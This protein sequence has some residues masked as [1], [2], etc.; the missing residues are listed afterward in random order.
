MLNITVYAQ[1]GGVVISNGAATADPSAMLDVISTEKGML[2]PRVDIANLAATAPV[3]NPALSLLVYNTNTTTGVGFYYWNGTAWASV[4]GAGLP[5][6]PNAG[7]MVYW[8]GT[9]WVTIAATVN[10]GATLQMISG[11]PTWTG[12]TPPSLPVI[13]DFRDG[14]VV[15]YVDATGQHGLVC[16]VSDQ[17]TG[18][19]W[20]C[21]GTAI[22]GADETA[23][24]TGA[25]NTI[26]IEAG[27]TTTGTAADICANLSLNGH[28][29][30]FLPSKD[31]LN[32]MYINKATIDAIALA[33]GGTA[34]VNTNYWS[35][36]ELSAWMASSQ[37][38]NNGGY[39][40]SNKNL[41]L[42][43]VRAVRAF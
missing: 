32:E 36:T 12:G 15:F 21:G 16:A 41:L 10:E 5:T 7:D 23:I 14:G 43:R 2:V 42:Y 30:W 4:G 39:N 29:N 24:G 26:D 25:Q 3:T 22:S 37:I 38:L 34:F 11:V 18:A 13:G 31:E 19:V 1:T 33:N 9:A 40:T 20:G 6:T 35:S 8:N 17:S 27:C 28:T